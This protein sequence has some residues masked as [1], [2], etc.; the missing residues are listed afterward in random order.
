MKV[1]WP[2]RLVPFLLRLSH[3]YRLGCQNLYASVLQLRFVNTHGSGT[4]GASTHNVMM[5]TIKLVQQYWS[6]LVNPHIV[7]ICITEC[8][9]GMSEVNDNS[10]RS[11]RK[12]MFETAN[13]ARLDTRV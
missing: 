13:V 11:G 3:S 5:S 6:P 2:L 7:K 10:I 1:S 4:R 8:A 12:L 9:L